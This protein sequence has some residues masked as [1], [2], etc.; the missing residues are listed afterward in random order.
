ML[1]PVQITVVSILACITVSVLAAVD[2]YWQRS[3]EHANENRPENIQTTV[4]VANRNAKGQPF[5]IYGR[6]LEPD[7]KTPA[8]NV[9]VHTYHRDHDGFEFGVD[10][11]QYPAWQLQGWVKTDKDGKFEIQTIK[12]AS[13]HMGREGAHIHFTVVSE[14]YGKQWAPKVF[15]ADDPITQKQ[16][17]TISGRNNIIAE[18]KQDSEVQSIKIE[19]SLK[20]AADF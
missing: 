4:T 3:W 1:K 12:P 8:A 2:P 17:K 18:I 20:K 5:V 14:K 19:F 13:D 9:L 10:E 16:R 15:L 6:V 11:K 7:G